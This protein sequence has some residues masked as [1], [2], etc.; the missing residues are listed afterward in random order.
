MN[1]CSG[2]R[3]HFVKKL[4]TRDQVEF[5]SEIEEILQINSNKPFF[6]YI[7][8]IDNNHFPLVSFP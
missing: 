8:F 5:F 4:L 3:G 2:K 1:S 6:E 7:R